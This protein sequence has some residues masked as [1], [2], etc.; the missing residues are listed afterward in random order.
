M[1]WTLIVQTLATPVLAI[2]AIVVALASVRLARH[3]RTLGAH[4]VKLLDLNTAMLEA[5]ADHA[6]TVRELAEETREDRVV[7]ARPLLVRL[8]EPPPGIG[9]EPWA[10]VRV[11]NLGN[12]SALNVVIWMFAGGKLYRS[13][14]AEAQG[15]TG[16]LHLASGD[17]FAPGPVQ[18]ML[19]VGKAQGKL[20][21][22]TA[23]VG[24]SPAT[25]LTA[26]CFDQFRNRYKFTLR[27]ADP[28]DVWERG[29]DAPPWAGAWDPPFSLGLEP[30]MRPTD[31]TKSMSERDVARLV[32]ELHDVL[33]DLQSAVAGE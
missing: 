29:T 8:D 22:G 16:T 3:S 30:Q 15:F 12:G 1:T 21:P 27:T 11:R 9:D 33:H 26:Y 10:A 4:V 13:A 20:D 5:A 31:L 25:N 14:G 18:N 23:V 2:A 6:H 24:D 28:P 7:A 32:E 17:T 19:Y